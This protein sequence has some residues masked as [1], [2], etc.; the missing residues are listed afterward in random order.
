MENQTPTKSLDFKSALR[1]A[2]GWVF[3]LVTLVVTAVCAVSVITETATLTDATPI[4]MTLIA[5]LSA[6]VTTWVFNRTKEKIA[7]KE[8]S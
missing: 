1:P 8:G 5:A 4:F 6:P 7:G 3:V 2:L